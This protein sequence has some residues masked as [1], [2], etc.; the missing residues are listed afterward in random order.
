M[1]LLAGYSGDNFTGD[2]YGKYSFGNLYETILSESFIRENT[3]PILRDD[4]KIAGVYDRI[5]NLDIMDVGTGRQALTFALL[6]AK[7]VS[8]F[9]ISE[10]HVARFS[11][12]L[13]E[14]YPNLPITTEH[15]DLCRNAPPKEK[16]DF[17]Y[18]NGIVQHFSNT[19]TGLKNCAASVKPNGRIWVYFY[20][21][22]TFKW[23][24]CSMIRKMLNAVDL[25]ASFIASALIYSEGRLDDP[26]VSLIM[27]DFFAPYI[28]LYSPF[29]YIEF[30][31]RLGF[32]KCA[33]NDLEPLCEVDHSCLHH[34]ATIVY[35]RQEMLE[36]D[37]VDTA[38]LLTPET[39][40]DQL[41][42]SLYENDGPK[43]CI[44]A[45]LKVEELVASGVNP[46]VLWSL[47]LAMHKLAAP[48]YYGGDEYASDYDSLH[49]CLT[50]VSENAAI[51]T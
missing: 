48:Q 18:L 46:V 42:P 2:L 28:H 17:V 40:V 4:L 49:R 7:S 20:R 10:D 16:Y 6:D 36:I 15:I 33:S 12:L 27:D 5:K 39:E 47:C 8:H 22:G 51:L 19:A 35:E 25:D 26:A 24:V 1:G 50:H 43:R 29:Q 23:F 13:S 31:E 3:L 45:F 34:S 41:D 30:M 38:G 37:E 9:D 11:A 14:N 32:K 21:S 44:E